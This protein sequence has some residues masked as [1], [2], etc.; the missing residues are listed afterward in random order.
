MSSLEVIRKSV[1][2]ADLGVDHD[3]QEFET[4]DDCERSLAAR[5]FLRFNSWGHAISLLEEIDRLTGIM[6][7]ADKWAS[8]A[9]DALWNDKASVGYLRSQQP[10]SINYAIW[11]MHELL[12]L[13]PCERCESSSTSREHV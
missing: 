8:I 6:A 10:H 13:N 5:N 9:H 12:R 2:D 4:C 11:K 1:E 7:E 3:H